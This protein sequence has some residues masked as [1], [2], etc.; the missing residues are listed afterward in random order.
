MK[1]TFQKNLRPERIFL[2][3]FLFRGK[4]QGQ[5]LQARGR[6]GTDLPVGGKNRTLGGM[7]IVIL[8]SYNDGS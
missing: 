1:H 8:L 4:D 7:E 2:H 3:F 5:F 6:G